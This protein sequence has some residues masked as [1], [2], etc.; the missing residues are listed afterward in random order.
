MTTPELFEKF[1]QAFMVGDLDQITQ[2]LAPDFEW[3]QPGGQIYSG[4]EQALQAMA[5]RFANPDGPRFTNSHFEFY[6]DTVVQTY[7]VI[8]TDSK[9]ELRHVAGTDVY[10]V[11]AGLIIL[12]DA[13]WKQLG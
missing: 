11:K 2:C 13:Y 5:E 10:K 1:S 7:Q 3:R 8:A 9:G 4:R 6:D 12:K